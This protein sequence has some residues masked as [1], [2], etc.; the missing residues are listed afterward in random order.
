MNNSVFMF[1]Y[2]KIDWLWAL[3]IFQMW[4]QNFCVIQMSFLQ[5]VAYEYIEYIYFHHPHHDISYHINYL[6]N[7]FISCVI[8]LSL[9]Y[10]YSDAIMSMM[11]SQF[12]GVSIVYSTICSG[13][14]HRKHQSSASLAFVRGIYQSQMDSLHKGPVN[15]KNV[16]IWLRYQCII[17][18]Y[19]FKHRY[20]FIVSDQFYWY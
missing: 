3:S 20:I 4:K 6:H 15:R 2:F 19:S 11:E 9:H 10:H 17:L 1:L 14:D 12:T 8:S 13:A 18:W 16:F 5:F 7:S